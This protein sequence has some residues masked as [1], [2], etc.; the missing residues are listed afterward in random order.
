MPPTNDSQA[1][2]EPAAPPAVA[3]PSP[4]D[5]PVPPTN[6]EQKSGFIQKLGG[7]KMRM[8]IF[9]LVFAGIGGYFIFHSF[10]AT[11]S[12]ENA[13]VTAFKKLSSNKPNQFQVT[14][15]LSYRGGTAFKTAKVASTS[16]I[17]K[18]GAI[19]TTGTLTVTKGGPPTRS[20]ASSY[21]FPYELANIY[22]AQYFKLSNTANFKK[23]L[24][25]NSDLRKYLESKDDNY[26][27]RLEKNWYYVYPDG[28]DSNMAP[29]SSDLGCLV[30]T[31][32]LP[33]SDD[34]GSMA[35]A[36][37]TKNPPLQITKTK[38]D[39]L[40]SYTITPTKGTGSPNTTVPNNYLGDVSNLDYVKGI[41][42]CVQLISHASAT[43]KLS[44]AISSGNLTL[45]ITVDGNKRIRSIN[46]NNGPQ[47]AN[48]ATIAGP[49]EPKASVDLTITMN[50]GGNRVSEIKWPEAPGDFNSYYRYLQHP[51]NGENNSLFK[52]ALPSG[53]GADY[54]SYYENEYESISLYPDGSP[55][56][57]FCGYLDSRSNLSAG[58]YDYDYTNGESGTANSQI[59]VKTKAGKRQNALA[60]IQNKVPAVAKAA[61]AKALAKTL[62]AAEAKSRNCTPDTTDIS[63]VTIDGKEMERDATTYGTC[64][65]AYITP[66]TKEVSY[67]WSKDMPVNNTKG[68][69]D[70]FYAFYQQ[71]PTDQNKMSDYETMV[72][73]VDL[74]L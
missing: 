51:N 22:G 68:S 19:G 33:S 71:K 30:N 21:A 12:N 9:A 56:G 34:L 13:I 1:P 41:N 46:F 74:K 69:Y 2:N 63:T 31:A 73:A 59:D 66:G 18:N 57:A 17:D 15:Q 60:T 8:L 48:T 11:L 53:W 5:A 29:N 49:N 7:S 32:L 20:L 16:S 70:Y 50:Y 65:K 14:G 44:G 58:H 39:S 61:K 6:S 4:A 64:S 26:L 38:K 52:Y 45:T 35:R 42:G 72:K 67:Y 43:D 62:T 24:P 10:A 28:T 40:T 36:Y 55:T 23:V 25:A 3:P 54:C 47:P 27:S 37:N